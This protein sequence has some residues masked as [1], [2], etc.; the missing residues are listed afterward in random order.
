MPGKGRKHK[1]GDRGSLEEEPTESKR[2]N[3]AGAESGNE[4]TPTEKPLETTEEPSLSELREMLVDIQ[5]TV[6]NIL[7]E[8]R[9]ICDEVSELKATVRKQQ[10]E[11]TAVK[12]A[13]AQARKQSETERE[14]PAARKQLDEQEEELQELY[15][16]QD[17]L[18]QYT[19]KNSLGFH[20]VT[21]SAYTSTKEA[22]MK[23]ANAVEVPVVAEDIE[24]SHKLTTRGSK[25]IIA[26]FIN[27]K[28]KSSL[29]RARVKLKNVTL[30]DL[31]PGATYASAAQSNRIFIN[32]NLTSYRR[33]IMSRA[34]EKRR[35]GELLS[36][37]SL[38]GTIFVKTSPDGRPIKISEPEDLDYV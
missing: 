15:F 30:S 12:D 28:V 23:I 25:A 27:H 4:S 36:V 6:N 24:I 21:E 26:K 22:V 32:E 35:D 9:R 5:I 18:E 13:L 14:L 20:G 16:L 7:L 8:N 2:A 33:R 38:D 3:M 29:Y 19:R 17:H 37:W 10:S 31:F 34:N 1:R 11:I